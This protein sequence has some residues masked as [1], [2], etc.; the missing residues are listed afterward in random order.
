MMVLALGMSSPLSMMLV[1]TRTSTSPA[2]EA[3]HHPLQLASPASGRGHS[4]ARLGHELLQPTRDL[5]ECPA[6]GCGRRRPARRDPAR[7]GWPAAPGS[8]R[9]RP[10]GL[11]GQAFLGRRLDHAQIA[12]AGQRHVQRARDGRGR[13]VSTSTSVRNC[14]RRSLCATPKRCSSSMISRPR[15]LKTTSFCKQAMGADDDVHWP[16]RQPSQ[17]FLLLGAGAEAREHL[18]LDREGRRRSWKV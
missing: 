9:I 6:P 4:E 15:S 7:A 8:R 16:L 17:T 13:Q 14:F 10:R 3:Q 12:H 1:H 5:I 18:H 2:G 11:D